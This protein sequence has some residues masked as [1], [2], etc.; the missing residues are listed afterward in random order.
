MRPVFYYILP[1]AAVTVIAMFFVSQH[2]RH[3][4]IGYEL[5]RLRSERAELRKRARKLDFEIDKVSERERLV[6]TANRIGVGL[7]PPTPEH[8]S[9]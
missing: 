7:V 1:I 2:S 5:T 8:E 4:Q 9:D 3:R 6:E